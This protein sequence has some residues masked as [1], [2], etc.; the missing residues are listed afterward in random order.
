MFE[1]TNWKETILERYSVACEKIQTKD[2][3]RWK[4]ASEN[5]VGVNNALGFEN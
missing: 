2:S 4:K 1:K 5:G 3:K